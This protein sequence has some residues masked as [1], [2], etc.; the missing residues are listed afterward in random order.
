MNMS[1]MEV[2]PQLQAK[3]ITHSYYTHKD[4]SSHLADHSK[5]QW[6]LLKTSRQEG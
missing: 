6:Q 2:L 1:N 4:K 3:A 5:E